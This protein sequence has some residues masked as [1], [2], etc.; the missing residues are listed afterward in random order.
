MSAS[1]Y[2]NKRKVHEKH[3]PNNYE[4]KSSSPKHYSGPTQTARR[5]F[6]SLYAG[7]KRIVQRSF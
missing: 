5:D 1:N 6:A 7:N 3:T 4:Y 2:W